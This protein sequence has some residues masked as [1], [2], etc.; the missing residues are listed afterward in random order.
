MTSPEGS[1]PSPARTTNTCG[2]L[3]LT[4][5]PPAMSNM[6]VTRSPSTTLLLTPWMSH[7]GQH[8]GVHRGE[9]TPVSLYRNRS[10]TPYPPSRRCVAPGH[11]TVS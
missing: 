11:V 1:P 2:L 10:L 3:R 4:A 9:P 6:V 7:F 5:T 8:R